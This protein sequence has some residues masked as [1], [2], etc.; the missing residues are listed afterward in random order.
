MLR[1]WPTLLGV[2][3]ASAAYA[4]AREVNFEP[5]A[6]L[7]DGG[8]DSAGPME[9]DGGFDAGREAATLATPNLDVPIP[10]VSQA[11]VAQFNEGDALFDLPLREADGLG[12]L[13]T[14][15]KCSACHQGGLRGPGL[16]QK[17]VV[18]EADGITPSADQS[19]LAYGNTVHPRT[20]AGAKTPIRKPDGVSSV[21]VT[22]RFGPAILGRGYMEAIRDDEILRQEAEQ[23]A[24]GLS[25]RV[26]WVSYASEPNTDTRYH[27]HKKGDRLIGRF[28]LKARIATLDDF[29]ADAF[30]GD[31]GITSPLRPTEVRNP[32]GL[33][34]D[35]K[36][37]IDL[38][39]D[40]V[41]R[42]TEYVRLLAIPE[43]IPAARGSALFASTGCAGCHTPSMKTRADY[44]IGAAAGIDA[45]IYSDL[46]LHDMGDALADG[47]V[48]GQ[49]SGREWRTTPLMGL[50]YHRGYMHDGRARTVAEAIAAH[51]SRG[52]EAN[53][54][55]ERYRTL[56]EADRLLVGE[57][58][59]DL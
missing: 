49:A 58:T 28:G 40:S 30:Q 46:L 54:S 18:V 26:H 32:D 22:T 43:R 38:S 20:T 45:P 8:S 2:L 55:V 7:F 53:P 3:A 1:S 12:P 13:F 10:G 6:A 5:S 27:Q 14:E 59:L 56:S 15:T 37:G 11:Q 33:L 44:P 24:R 29:T 19:A 41:N 51:E 16:V 9:F 34:D 17:M 36:P 35:K 47:I 48:E 42:R 4:C 31:M 25:G 52:S 39:Y 50:R 23:P 57:F 21:K